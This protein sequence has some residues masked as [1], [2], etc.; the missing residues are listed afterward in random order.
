MP[1]AATGWHL[2]HDAR[3]GAQ[4]EPAADGGS[5]ARLT[6]ADGARASQFAA[7]VADLPA[8]SPIW[9]RLHVQVSA[10]A[11]MRVSVQGRESRPG[12]G[13][14]WRHSL[15]ADPTRRWVTLEAAAFRPIRPASGAMP[16]DR[17]HALLFVLDTVNGR[18]GTAVTLE[19]HAMQFEAAR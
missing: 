11:P 5:R 8:R 13:L 9:A 10:S 2:E 15:L 3:S 6:L 14:R 19:V 7:L 16:T 4:H 1:L 18:P 17:L 12:E